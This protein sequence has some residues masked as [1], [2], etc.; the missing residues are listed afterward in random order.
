[1][2]QKNAKPLKDLFYALASADERY[3]K[4]GYFNFVDLCKSVN[5]IEDVTDLYPEH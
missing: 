2:V 1:M 5:I 3:P 4:L